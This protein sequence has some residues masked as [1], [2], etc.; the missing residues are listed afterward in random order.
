[1]LEEMG[2]LYRGLVLGLVIAAPVG[3]VG[4]LCI[5]RTLQ[6]GTVNGLATGLGAAIAD[7]IFG[8]IAVW[9]VTAI[10]DFIH[11]Y[12]ATIRLV[13]GLIV[14]ATAAHT[15]RDHPKPPHPSAAVEK[16]LHLA[17]EQSVLK[18]SR[19]LLS[20]FIITLTN[21][22]TLFG[23]LAVVATFADITK[24]V[25]ADMMIGGIFA[26]SALWWVLLSGGVGLLRG[27]FTENRII[28]MNRVTAAVLAAL[29]LWAVISGIEL[30]LYP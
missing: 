29:A 6:K 8:A 14:L 4:L 30:Y 26:G 28:A 7:A 3:P 15:W 17:Q 22:L 19:A 16:F 27:H 10:L 20:G 21:P 13:G 23:T 25:E 1:M 5:R 24:A 9:G 12:E 11:H 18:S 2:V